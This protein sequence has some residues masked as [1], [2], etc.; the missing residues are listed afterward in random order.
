[1]DTLYRNYIKKLNKIIGKTNQRRHWRTENI[2]N[3]FQYTIDLSVIQKD[4]C[5]I[6]EREYIRRIDRSRFSRSPVLRGKMKSTARKDTFCVP[7]SRQ[8]SS[9][10]RENGRRHSLHLS[11]GDCSRKHLEP[12][13]I[14][15]TSLPRT[16]WTWTKDRKKRRYSVTGDS[17]HVPHVRVQ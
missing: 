2:T 6:E 1:M 12:A 16:I 10:A 17:A 11:P 8:T 9:N 14:R 13:F 3:S 7:T 4:N 15:D 5:N